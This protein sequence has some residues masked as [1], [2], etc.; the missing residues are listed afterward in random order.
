MLF[1]NVS[2]CSKCIFCTAFK[3]HFFALIGFSWLRSVN[4]RIN[5]WNALTRLS[6]L[7]GGREEPQPT[8]PQQN[9]CNHHEKH[10]KKTSCDLL[11]CCLECFRSKNTTP[12]WHTFQ[13]ETSQLSSIYQFF[14][15][16]FLILLFLLEWLLFLFY[17][18][19]NFTSTFIFMS[20]FLYFSLLSFN[21]YFLF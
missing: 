1:I 6:T 8:I 5:Q 16:I 3:M 12:P 21:Q 20:S 10:D 15:L 9:K 4:A 7:L 17:P 2:K 11:N 19:K 18:H 13:K 14:F